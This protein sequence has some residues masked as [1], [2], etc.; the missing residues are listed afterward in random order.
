VQSKPIHLAVSGT[1][2]TGKTTTTEALSIAT[3]IR[4]THA[5]TLREILME[6]RPGRQL[7]ELSAGELMMV[8]LRRLEERIHHEAEAIGREGS[9]VCDGSV[10][11]E[12]VYGEARM[13]AGINPGAGSLQRTY[14]AIVG[15]PF[16]KFYQTYMDACGAVAKDRAKRIYD[17]YVHLPVE[18]NLVEDGH[19]PV[20]EKF[21][22]LSDQM[23]LE[24][25]DE[26]KIPYHVVGG[27]RLER[28]QRV[29]DIFDLPLVVPVDEAVELAEERVA[30]ARA[31]LE[32][33]YRYHANQRKK[34]FWRR[35]RYA[36][37]Y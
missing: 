15:L 19:R 32:E 35:M 9:F 24:T 23:L 16:K 17:A 36:L 5:M 2:S 4:R 1:Y 26:L 28:V 30:K 6:M 37:R 8:G 34:S 18:F 31:V 12:W 29:V 3:G 14:K 25:L 20:S 22:R 7:E 10:L 21:R 33:D 11:H 13:R 27:T